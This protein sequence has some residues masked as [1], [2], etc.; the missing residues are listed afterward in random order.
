MLATPMV[1]LFIVIEPSPE[2][3]NVE[4]MSGLSGGQIVYDV[5]RD[6]SKRRLLNVIEPFTMTPAKT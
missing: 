1:Q 4:S 2:R 6:P 3:T 5:D